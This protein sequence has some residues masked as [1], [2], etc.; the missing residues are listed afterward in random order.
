[1]CY[2]DYFKYA[3]FISGAHFFSLSSEMDFLGKFGSKNHNCQFTLKFG[4]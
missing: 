1:M 4:T 2:L 3:E